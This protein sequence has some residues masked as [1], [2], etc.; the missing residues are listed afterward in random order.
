MQARYRRCTVLLGG[1]RWA[2]CAAWTSRPRRCLASIRQQVDSAR[3]RALR[4]GS[5][6]IRLVVLRS[7]CITSA[8]GPIMPL[9]NDGGR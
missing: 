8:D 3:G 1:P 4:L 9:L 6:G 5:A 2:S 7:S